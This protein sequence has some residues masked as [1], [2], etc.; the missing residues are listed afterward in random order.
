MSAKTSKVTETS[1]TGKTSRTSKTPKTS[2]V[3]Q[4]PQVKTEIN[5]VWVLSVFHSP[6]KD[7]FTLKHHCYASEKDAQK[8]MKG[9]AME[10]YMEPI[11]Q[12]EESKYFEEYESEIH[13][14][15]SPDS[16]DYRRKFGFCRVERL[17]IQK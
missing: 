1:K 8:A 13:Y 5:K 15:E 6:Y 10:L 12:E 3:S 7:D 16:S 17:Q 11:I 14:R 9:Q 2:Q 4:V